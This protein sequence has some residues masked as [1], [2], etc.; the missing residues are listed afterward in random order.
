MTKSYTAPE[1]YRAQ[2]L[3]DV[4]VFGRQ[5]MASLASGAA[6]YRFGWVTMSLATVPVLVLVL[7]LVLGLI[8]GTRRKAA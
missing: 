7:V 3:N 8:V 2:G 5:A 4:T 6:L 1:K